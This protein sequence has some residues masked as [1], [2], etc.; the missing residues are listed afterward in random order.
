M[1]YID[2]ERKSFTY[3]LTEEQPNTTKNGI[4]NRINKMMNKYGN[5]T[6]GDFFRTFL[7]KF[8]ETC[9]AFS[10]F[11]IQYATDQKLY[12]FHGGSFYL[13]I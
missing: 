4:T 12:N 11:Y 9:N 7:L 5:L 3:A 1:Y 6:I 2:P 10:R 8:D 13:D